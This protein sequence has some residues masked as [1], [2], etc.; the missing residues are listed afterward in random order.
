M[1]C[2]FELL[3]RQALLSAFVIMSFLGTLDLGWL[4]MGEGEGR[5]PAR[6]A[7]GLEMEGPVGEE[8]S[9][10]GRPVLIPSHPL[11]LA[12]GQRLKHL[13]EL[14]ITRWHA[15]G[16]RG[17]GVKVAILDS[18][19]R[20]YRKHLAASLPA[21]VTVRSFRHDGNLEDRDSQHGI[22]CAE[23]VHAI[24][25][26]SDLLL[27]NW[28]PDDPQQFLA[29]VRWAKRQGAQVITC[30][31]ITPDWSDGEGG[32]EVH[33]ALAEILGPGTG[34]RDTLLFASAGNTAERHWLGTF[35]GDREGWHEWTEG[36]TANVLR[37]WN[38]ERVSAEL[39][40]P[41]G[42][43]YE[44]IIDEEETGVEI[45]RACTTQDGQE[46]RTCAVVRW[47]PGASSD[48]RVRVRLAPGAEAGRFHVVALNANLDQTT[49]RGSVCFPA[50]GPEVIAMGAVDRQGRREYYS[51]CGPNS[52]HPKPDLVAAVPFYSLWRERSFAGTSAASPQG[53][54]LAALWWS[55]YPNWTANQVRA[56]LQNSA[57][58]LGT[59]G[60]D[61]ETGHG[62]IHLPPASVDPQ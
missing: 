58:D 35:R 29:A 21:S 15:V 22:L 36:V 56:A 32:G 45:G 9:P 13:H 26:G 49:S 19:W 47:L 24:A 34:D 38:E 18:G 30:S 14:G 28:E 6:T 55:R 31:V 3:R 43:D 11:W 46:D 1:P 8:A 41:P 2:F 5:G 44:L 51:A 12:L 4:N 53:A 40:C 62:V 57:R 16:H 61:W 27:A 25:P 23:I 7:P 42:S 48:Y 54:A 59:P 50:D 10:S 52:S 39:Y 17:E 37:P 33:Q 60:H 20:G